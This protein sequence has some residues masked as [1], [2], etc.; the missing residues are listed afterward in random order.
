MAKS[1]KR[2]F[3]TLRGMRDI[4]PVDWPYYEFIEGAS[5]R[6]SG[7]YGYSRIGTPILE[8]AGLFSRSAGQSEMVIK[9]M[10][11]F[12][13]RGG[14]SVAIRPELTA[15]VARAY[16]EHGFSNMPQPIK[17][18]YFDTGMRY[19]RP[20]AGRYRQFYQVGFEI[21]GEASPVA[22]TELIVMGYRLLTDLGLPIRISINSLGDTESRAAY[23]KALN[24]YLKP[25][26]K[27]LPPDDLA[28]FERNSL[29]ILDSKEKVTQTLLEDAPKIIDYL[30]P[31]SREHFLKVVDYLDDLELPYVIDSRLVRGLDYYTGIVFEYY[32]DDTEITLPDGKKKE[33]QTAHLAL[34]GGG[35][36]DNLIEEVGGKATPAVGS[37]F[38]VERI[39][40][41]LKD[42]QIEIPSVP[43]PE[44]FV[45]QIGDE[46]R[47]KAFVL[48]EDLRSRGVRVSHAF[49]KEG[50]KAQLEA[51]NRLG[52]RFAIILGQ[53]E[54]LDK[55]I[56]IRDM[57]N[58]IQE[59]VDYKKAVPEVLKRLQRA[60]K[61]AKPLTK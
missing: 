40:V 57:E 6:I 47:K 11:V 26:L 23:K 30:S 31:A 16:V 43:A 10:Y 46:A 37:G 9:E 7:D 50:I 19:E 45:G 13:D 52:V 25:L 60:S 51:A 36:Y 21:F 27:Q 34:G 55:T 17:L 42:R 49:T 29:R 14:D 4:L 53:K 32:S 2:S 41:Q 20:Q 38:G 58:G 18:W 15:P 59:T 3:Q 5:K 28:R 22:D 61:P 33:I 54:L 39:I 56:L 24:A 35:R 44:V 48:F 8:D 12:D 1:S